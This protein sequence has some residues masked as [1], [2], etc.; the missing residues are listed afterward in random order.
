LRDI[1]V[2]YTKLR[3]Y[4]RLNKERE[5]GGGKVR[6]LESKLVVC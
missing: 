2:T 1:I 5:R 6:K 4:K 3:L